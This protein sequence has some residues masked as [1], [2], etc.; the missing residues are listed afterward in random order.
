MLGVHFRP[1]SVP[2]SDVKT[3]SKGLGKK[4]I[5]IGRLLELEDITL[6]SI[7]DTQG[8][9]LEECAYQMLVEW[10][11]TRS[12]EAT[13]ECLGKA[14]LHKAVHLKD[15]VEKYCIEQS[16]ESPNGIVNF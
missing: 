4:W 10:K 15:V 2:E 13:Y 8:G 14:L 11:Q 6:E 16:G 7:R 1:G 5:W 12:G 3:F 9:N